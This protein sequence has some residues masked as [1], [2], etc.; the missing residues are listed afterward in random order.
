MGVLQVHPEE[1]GPKYLLGNSSNNPSN[2]KPVI[3]L[4]DILKHVICMVEEAGTTN[5]TDCVFKVG[6]AFT[7]TSV[8]D[9]SLGRFISDKKRILPL[10]LLKSEHVSLLQM[11]LPLFRGK[12]MKKPCLPCP[13]YPQMPNFGQNCSKTS[14]RHSTRV[15]WRTKQNLPSFFQ[16][17]NVATIFDQ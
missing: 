11:I 1:S 16:K 12:S 15:C 9:N 5:M 17:I 14:T 4:A 8:D 13:I 3:V 6:D 2:Q 7:K 10:F